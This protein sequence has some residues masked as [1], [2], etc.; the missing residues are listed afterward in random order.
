MSHPV[1]RSDKTPEE[2][3]AQRALRLQL[4]IA[5]ALMKD[6]TVERDGQRRDV[7]NAIDEAIATLR[8]T[9]R[10]PDS[11]ARRET[12]N[13]AASTL[14]S[15]ANRAAGNNPSTTINTGVQI[16]AADLLRLI[17]AE[18]PA[19]TTGCGLP[20]AAFSEALP[21]PTRDLQDVHRL[22]EPVDAGA[23]PAGNPDDALPARV[24][25]GD[26]TTPAAPPLAQTD[27]T[28]GLG[29]PTTGDAKEP[30]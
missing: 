3:A 19:G 9:L 30:T 4:R 21:T 6:E 13:H 1:R 22:S 17:P 28:D 27:A 15:A 25:S 24:R 10:L 8:E 7:G 2:L 18:T 5:R 14:L 26:G 16:A 23:L 29:D 12:K 20:P 11:Q